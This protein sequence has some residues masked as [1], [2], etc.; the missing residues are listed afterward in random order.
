MGLPSA[1]LVINP[2]TAPTGMD[3]INV[4]SIQPYSIEI[5]WNELSADLNGGDDPIFY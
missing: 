1:E 2:D 4:G 3:P 5:T